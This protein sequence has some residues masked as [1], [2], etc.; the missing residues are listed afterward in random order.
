M[1]HISDGQLSEIFFCAALA[2]TLIAMVFSPLELDAISV[3]AA[4]V[5]I[6]AGLGGIYLAFCA[7]REP[8]DEDNSNSFLP[9]DAGT[10]PDNAQPPEPKA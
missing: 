3:A 9:E 8:L 1:K 5:A 7:W 2:A 10:D 4:T 6:V